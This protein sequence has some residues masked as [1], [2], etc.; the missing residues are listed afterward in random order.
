[1]KQKKEWLWSFPSKTFLVGEYSALVEGGCLLLNTHPRFVQLK[2]GQFLDP[3][4]QRGGFGASS[5]KWL[6]DYLSFNNLTKKEK[7][8]LFDSNRNKLDTKLAIQLKETYQKEMK[9]SEPK[10]K[11]APSGVDILSQCI[12]Q[13]AYI[14]VQKNIFK[15]LTWPFKDMHFLIFPTGN[16]AFTLRHLKEDIK[17]PDCNLLSKRSQ[18]VINAFLGHKENLFLN[19]L[20][21][22]DE[23]LE[24]LGFCCQQTLSLKHHIK[25]HFPK[26]TV[27]G[28]GALGMD[29]LLIICTSNIFSDVKGFIEKDILSQ[30]EDRIITHQDLTDGI[31]ISCPLLNNL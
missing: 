9:Q 3:H 10:L 2:N 7:E 26:V 6:C 25:K 24:N 16:K 20:K 19:A 18:E 21:N 8:H 17:I 29:T 28:C 12:G 22:F 23:C 31:S 14:D 1:M 27:K 11:I 5:A 30:S 15:S 4:Q 13:I